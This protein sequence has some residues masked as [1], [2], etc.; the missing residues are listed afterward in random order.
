[1]I[2]KYNNLIC[3]R[4]ELTEYLNSIGDYHPT[5]SLIENAIHNIDKVIKSNKMTTKFCDGCGEEILDCTHHIK[6]E[7]GLIFHNS[8][9]EDEYNKN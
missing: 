7:N 8:D 6:Y 4:Y 1:M 3:A 2:S 9:C 5:R